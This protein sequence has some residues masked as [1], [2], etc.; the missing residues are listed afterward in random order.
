M[1]LV[2]SISEDAL[3]APAGLGAGALAEIDHLRTQ[4]S[5]SEVEAAL[6]GAAVEPRVK[7][8]PADLSRR[9]EAQGEDVVGQTSSAE[10]G[11]SVE[12][13]AVGPSA[14][15]CPKR[16]P[17]LAAHAQSVGRVRDAVAP[18]NDAPAVVD[19]VLGGDALGAPARL[20]LLRACKIVWPGD[21]IGRPHE[22]PARC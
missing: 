18:Q 21:V 9:A 17:A 19:G 4:P 10:T 1:L 15:S 5:R 14:L 20:R 6:A 7:L 22:V 2:E 12:A 16:K 13:A 3:V 8:A 11:G